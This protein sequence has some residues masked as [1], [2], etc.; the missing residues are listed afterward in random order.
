[1]FEAIVFWTGKV[2]C[3]RAGSGLGEY[4]YAVLE[5]AANAMPKSEEDMVLSQNQVWFLRGFLTERI[6][7]CQAIYGCVGCS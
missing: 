4:C 6:G 2:K 5:T 3:K 1:M 7:K